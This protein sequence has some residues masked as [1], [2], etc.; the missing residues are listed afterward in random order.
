MAIRDS[1][2]YL[3]GIEVMLFSPTVTTL[4]NLSDGDKGMVLVFRKGS[5]FIEE[6][7]KE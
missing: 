7:F 5:I 3:I 4:S 1:F 2:S 6:G